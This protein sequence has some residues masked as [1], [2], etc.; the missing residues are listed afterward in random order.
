MCDISIIC[1]TFNAGQVI[2]RMILSVLNQ[3]FKSYELIIVDGG[4]TD[5][6]KDILSKYSSSLI[7]ISEKDQG[8]YDATNKGIKKSVG[9][10]LYFIGA[11]DIL[12]NNN[13]LEDISIYLNGQWDVLLCN[14][15]VSRK[16]IF[17]SCYSNKIW[18]KN[19]VSHQGAIYNRG[20]FEDYSYDINLKISSDYDLNLYLWNRNCK[21]KC[22]NTII[23]S[24]SG[25]GLSSK[26]MFV[27]YKEEILV[28]NKYLKNS[29][30][31]YILAL[32]TLLR[33]FVKKIL[34]IV[35]LV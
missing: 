30:L 26:V 10:W 15:Y 28:R 6:T 31:K 18:L 19:T 32:F 17:V 25:T 1:P 23:C 33:Y 24:Y 11:D 16:D 8:I 27:G 9:R 21:V 14:V 13:V 34:Y 35:K 3:T 22:I 29:L 4:S 7:Y 12:F 5:N 2:E 20:V